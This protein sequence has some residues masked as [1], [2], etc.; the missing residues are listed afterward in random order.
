[1][2]FIP[3]YI[4]NENIKC[5]KNKLKLAIVRIYRYLCIILGYVMLISLLT[6]RNPNKIKN[7][8]KRKTYSN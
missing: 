2:E 4:Y 1:M 8:K 6:I 7:D 3:L 5:H